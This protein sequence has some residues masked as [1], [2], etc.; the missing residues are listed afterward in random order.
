MKGH[1]T[2][3]RGSRWNVANLSMISH[4]TDCQLVE[5]HSLANQCHTWDVHK[6]LT[7]GINEI[8]VSETLD[9]TLII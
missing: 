7:E 8:Q 5:L 9:I 2:L 6:G 1:H 3:W 4:E